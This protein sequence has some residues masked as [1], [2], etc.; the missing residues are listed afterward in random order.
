MALIKF[1]L[2]SLK[3]KRGIGKKW[4]EADIF[5]LHMCSWRYSIKYI[6]NSEEMCPWWM[7]AQIQTSH[8]QRANDPRRLRVWTPANDTESCTQRHVFQPTPPPPHIDTPATLT[9]KH[10]I[11]AGV[12]WVAWQWWENW[13]GICEVEFSLS[14]SLSLVINLL[15]IFHVLTPW[16]FPEPSTLNPFL[17]PGTPFWAP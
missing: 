1:R 15:Y 10:V 16:G 5:V 17:V 7:S 11:V 14:L 8:T 9:K 6:I 3:Q 12:S 4:A 2:N 13:E